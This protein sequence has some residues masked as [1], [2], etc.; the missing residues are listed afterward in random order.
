MLEFQN[1]KASFAK[2]YT[3]KSSEEVFVISKIKNTVPWPYAISDLNGEEVTG[4]FYEG[5]LQKTNQEKI[6]IEKIIKRKGD[7][8]YVICKEYDNLLNRD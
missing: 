5:D 3:P 1:R 7:K 4:S 2:R 8:L 6:R